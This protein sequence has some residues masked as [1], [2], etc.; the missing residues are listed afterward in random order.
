MY[1]GNK[2]IAPTFRMD[3]LGLKGWQQLYVKGIKNVEGI[4]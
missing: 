4:T 2:S 3:G 1:K